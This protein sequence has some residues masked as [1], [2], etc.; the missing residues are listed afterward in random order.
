[1][2]IDEEN[3]EKFKYPQ[4]RIYVLKGFIQRARGTA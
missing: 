1:V 2:Y 4:D 3:R